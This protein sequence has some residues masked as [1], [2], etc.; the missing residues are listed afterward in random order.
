LG[1]DDEGD[2]D[3][4]V[5]WTDAYIRERFVERHYGDWFAEVK[6]VLLAMTEQ[7]VLRP[8]YMLLVGLTWESRPGVTLVGDSAHL[9]TPFAG[10]GV[11]VALMDALELAQGVVDCVTT[12]NV[13]EDSL[14]LML[15]Q[16]ERGMFTRSC[17]EAAKTSTAMHLQFQVDGAERM[18]K[19][20][21]GG[22]Q[23]ED[24]VFE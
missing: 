7:P 13:D 3:G 14:A 21:S 18:V 16:Y 20:M 1:L 9:M 23:P 15:Q 4:G 24:I 11:N 17:K 22:L 8:L 10:V 12:G 19:A 5:D 2:T 6:Q